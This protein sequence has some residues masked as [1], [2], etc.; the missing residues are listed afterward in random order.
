MRKLLRWLALVM[1]VAL[2]GCP[3]SVGGPGLVDKVKAVEV[4]QGGVVVE[5]ADQIGGGIRLSVV[6]DRQTGNRFIV[7]A[8]WQESVAICPI[9]E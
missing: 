2:A 3:N 1:L 4:P 6:R 7:A 9:G 5:S 8:Y